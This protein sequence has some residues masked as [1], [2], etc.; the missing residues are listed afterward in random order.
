ME[1][2]PHQ[3]HLG[4]R[5]YNRWAS[6]VFNGK[7]KGEQGKALH[8]TL[9]LPPEKKQELLISEN[10]T[11]KPNRVLGK[12]QEQPS[13]LLH[14]TFTVA[15]ITCWFV[16]FLHQQD[17]TRKT[18]NTNASTTCIACWQIWVTPP[19]ARFLSRKSKKA[20]NRAW[21]S[22]LHQGKS[23]YSRQQDL[24]CKG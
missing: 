15:D 9:I 17:R 3:P 4:A 13:T 24:F 1:T 8:T 16:T 2:F 14:T 23:S 18:Q 11:K 5:L 6:V 21:L 19:Q 12:K 7:Q 22:L 20:L 10:N